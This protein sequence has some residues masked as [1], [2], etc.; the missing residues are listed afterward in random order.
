MWLIVRL[1]CRAEKCWMWWMRF[2]TSLFSCS[3]VAGVWAEGITAFKLELV[4]ILPHVFTK[5]HTTCLQRR[6]SAQENRVNIDSNVSVAWRGNEAAVRLIT[7]SNY[8]QP[9]ENIPLAFSHI[10]TTGWLISATDSSSRVYWGCLTP[11][12]W[13]YI[14]SNLHFNLKRNHVAKW[15]FGNVGRH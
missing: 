4:L 15:T 6:L 5:R 1:V 13:R 7:F 10:K 8:Q 11:Q 12:L 14:Q 3:V 9:G 2:E